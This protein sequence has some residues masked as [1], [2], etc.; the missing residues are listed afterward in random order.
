MHAK[1][2]LD[3]PIGVS[4]QVA[5]AAAAVSLLAAALLQCSIGDWLASGQY[6]GE[7]TGAAYGGAEVDQGLLHGFG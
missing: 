4:S 7:F 5:F 6:R 1:R 2:Q 3:W